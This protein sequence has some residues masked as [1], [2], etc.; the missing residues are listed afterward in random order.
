MAKR[1]SVEPWQHWRGL[2]GRQRANGQSVA[3]F[4]KEVG[5]STASFYRWK[6]RLRRPKPSNGQTTRR[7]SLVPVRVVNDGTVSGGKLEVQWPGGVVMRV[8]GSCDAQTI[9]A[10]VSALAAQAPGGP[11]PC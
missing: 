3:A 7:P 10:I 8:A 1:R 2:I 6:R 5:V 11:R 9:H 4:C